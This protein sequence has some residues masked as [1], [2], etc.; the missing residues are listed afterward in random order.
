MQH[1]CLCA[2]V[3]GCGSA[4]LSSPCTVTQSET[5]SLKEAKGAALTKQDVSHS[6]ELPVWHV[7]SDE[8]SSLFDVT[9]RGHHVKQNTG[10][11][12]VEWLSFLFSQKESRRGL[13]SVF[14]PQLSPRQWCFSLQATGLNKLLILEFFPT[15]LSTDWSKHW[16]FLLLKAEARAE[17]KVSYRYPHI[18]FASPSSS[19][20]HW[21]TL[22]DAASLAADDPGDLWLAQ[23]LT[24]ENPLSQEKPG[25]SVHCW[26]DRMSV[27]LQSCHNPTVLSFM[28]Q[29]VRRA[30][31]CS[32]ERTERQTTCRLELDLIFFLSL[33][34]SFILSLSL[35]IFCSSFCPLPLF[36][37]F[38]FL[39]LFLSFCLS[40][41]HLPLRPFCHPL[42]P[43]SLT[44][45]PFCHPLCPFCLP[46]LLFCLPLLASSEC[47]GTWERKGHRSG[48]RTSWTCRT[49]GADR[50]IKTDRVGRMCMRAT[51]P[52]H[53]KTNP[54][55]PL[56][57]QGEKESIQSRT[58]AEM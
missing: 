22:I 56:R 33:F 6:Q 1:L 54:D 27:L 14:L 34:Y 10:F 19:F 39:F 7:C 57:G 38:L 44:L 28:P 13:N 17:L 55:P 45:C 30:R 21:I 25:H 26:W 4:M 9:G 23:P 20:F 3:W 37:L 50:K 5:R 24:R 48:L 2:D 16:L 46:F 31:G 53:I 12:L 18:D 58:I 41:P 36:F 49:T 51:L 8:K 52:S 11:V 15:R 40:L 42:S 32:G 43:F 29:D 35:W 47:S